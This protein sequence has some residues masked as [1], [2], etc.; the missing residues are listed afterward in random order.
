[1]TSQHASTRNGRSVPVSVQWQTVS[2]Q[3]SCREH[4]RLTLAGPDFPPARPGQFVTIAAPRTPERE[5]LAAPFYLRRAFSIAGLRR[6][7]GHVEIDVI[8]RVIGAATG[9]MAS[10]RAGDAVSVVGPLGNGM[11]RPPAMRN[12]W[13]AAGGVGLPP[14]LWMAEV[15]NEEGI[16]ATAFFGARCADLVPLGIDRALSIPRDASTAT[17]AAIEFA[18]CAVP[19]VLCTDDGSLGFR[20]RVV[21]AI[22]AYWNANPGGRDNL[23]VYACG[24]EPMLASLADWTG[25]HGVECYVCMERAMACGVGT[26]QSCVVPVRS[27]DG[28]EWAYRLCCTDGPVFD[29]RTVLWSDPGSGAAP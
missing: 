25:G 11:P 18:R 9:W 17:F 13:L 23:V 5:E 22:D 21:D 12:A 4:Y 2:N 27:G 1:M 7:A 16:A 6:T 28:D 24:P 29:A 26:C 8:Y 3:A 10:L 15:L 14:V 20:G 19:T